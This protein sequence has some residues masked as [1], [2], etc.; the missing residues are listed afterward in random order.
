MAVLATAGGSGT[1]QKRR[2]GAL[3]VKQWLRGWD[4]VEFSDEGHKRRPDPSFLIFSIP[5]VELRSLCGINRRQT[6]KMMPRSEDLGIQRQHDKSRSNEI[7]RFVEYGFPWSTLSDAKRASEEFNDLRKPGWLPTSIVV[8]ILKPQDKRQ[9]GAVVDGVDIVE[10]HEA[11]GISTLHLPYE[12]WSSTWRPTALPPFEVIDGQHRLFAFENE[13]PNFELPVVAF[14]GLDLSWQ[15]Y[16]FWTINIKPKKI[17]PSLAFD[18]YPLLRGEDWLDQ[19]EGHAV[20]RE[21]RSQELTEAMWSHPA[22][23]WY[24]RINMLGERQIGGVTQSAW[25]KSLMAT[26]VRRWRGRGSKIGGLF[27]GRLSVEEDVLGWSRAQQ[28][29]FLIFA[30][31]AFKQAIAASKDPWAIDLRRH[32]KP[33][34]KSGDAAFYGRF[35]LINTDQGVRGFLHV[36]NDICFATAPRLDLRE[37]LADEDAAAADEAAVSSALTSLRQQ[38]VSEFLTK[39]VAEMAGFD[40]RT[41][42]A[43]DLSD[44]DRRAK[45]VFRGS[46]GYKEIRAQLLEH[47]SAASASD[48]SSVAKRVRD[49]V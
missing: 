12:T 16:L 3:R 23:P 8:N 2:V 28:G 14:H 48:I 32:V 45:L 25:I 20:Y 34:D 46:G 37:W 29:A 6:T 26:F 17:N 19:G 21:T 15:A 36:L 49:L 47:L 18:L 13:D 30:W 42:A 22:S 40:W 31:D 35:S 9:R 27:G 11:D 7:A 5:A 1:G 33:G 4:K 43:P 38:K 10:V 41:S 24:D 39:L 44:E